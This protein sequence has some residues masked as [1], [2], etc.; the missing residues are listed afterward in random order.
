MS[1]L[2]EDDNLLE[3]RIRR[4]TNHS[5]AELILYSLRE[6][7]GKFLK[8]QQVYCD[9]VLKLLIEEFM[10]KIRSSSEISK[11]A[12]EDLFF[13]IP[14]IYGFEKIIM[15]CVWESYFKESLVSDFPLILQRILAGEQLYTDFILHLEES[16]D[17]LEEVMKRPKAVSLIKTLENRTGVLF[18]TLLETPAVRFSQTLVFTS[19]VLQKLNPQT[20]LAAFLYDLFLR[21]SQTAADISNK[22]QAS[23]K[24]FVL[25]KLER[26][27]QRQFNFA[28][29]DRE[30]VKRDV[31]K[32]V[33]STKK[34]G[35]FKL[36]KSEPVEVLL[37]TDFLLIAKM[38]Q[39]L[40]GVFNLENVVVLGESFSKIAF[41]IK[42]TSR[43]LTLLPRNEDSRQEWVYL[44][45]LQQNKLSREHARGHV[46]ISDE[47]FTKKILKPRVKTVKAISSK[48]VQELNGITGEPTYAAIFRRQAEALGSEFTFFSSLCLRTF[49]PWRKEA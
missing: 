31:L 27:F 12:A 48:D 9:E 1:G 28:S 15:E 23:A 25:R 18:S 24:D 10:P 49:F 17:A 30:L 36:T 41:T 16:L 19:A 2:V 6:I 20:E 45:G 8:M 47:E 11:T 7:L 26:E 42:G 37:F 22:F 35:L 14:D 44:I 21:L 43:E 34:T 33:L 32:M 4:T 3:E 46:T 40:L 29:S 38:D 13:M 5:A 39:T